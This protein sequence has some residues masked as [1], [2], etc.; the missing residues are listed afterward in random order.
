MYALLYN[1]SKKQGGG[2]R[3]FVLKEK[4]EEMGLYGI[5]LLLNI[6]GSYKN[7]N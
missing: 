1:Y 2:R 6:I 5:F 4:S 7:F 3:L